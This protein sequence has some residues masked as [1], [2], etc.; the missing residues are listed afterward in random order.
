MSWAFSTGSCTI[1]AMACGLVAR[2]R[3]AVLAAHRGPTW[4][5]SRQ[6]RPRSTSPIRW[7]P[8]ADRGTGAENRPATA[9]PGFFS[10]G[11]AACQGPTPEEGRTWRDAIYAVIRATM[12][13]QGSHVGIERMCGLA[14]VSRAGYHRP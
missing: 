2:T 4:R 11:L 9:G 5:R 12:E 14:G 13:Q 6:S 1:G 7:G 10:R 8:E 3:F